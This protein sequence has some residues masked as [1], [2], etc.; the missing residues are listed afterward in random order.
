MSDVGIERIGRTK[1]DLRRFFDVAEKIYENDPHWVAPV[2]AD[3][4]KVLSPKNPFFRHAEIQLF[5]ARRDGAD[6]GRIAAILDRNHNDFQGERTGFFGYFESENDREV[7]DR[8]ID[9][10]ARWGRERG[11]SILRGPAN[12]SLNAEAGLLVD[13]FDA[14]PVFMMTYNPAYY[15]PLLEE[16]GFRKAKDLFAYRIEPSPEPLER[17]ERLAE[18]TRRRT[19][20]LRVRPITRRTLAADLPKVREVYNAAWQGNWG[21]VPMTREEI[22]FMAR[23]LRPL[24]DRD[25][26]CLA[27]IRRRDGSHEP[28]AF[29]V[30]LRDFNQ[31]IAPTRGRLLP[32]G[33]LKFL[34]AAPKVRT[35]RLLTFGVKREWRMRG[36]DA[37]VFAESLR[38]VLRRGFTSVEASWIVEDN[39]PMIR[40]IEFWR[41]HRYK[42]YRLYDR[43]L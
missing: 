38:A 1:G 9:A 40:G 34:L 31:A 5:I 37:V 6:V 21:F 39:F 20:D 32:F 3:L 35:L 43:P 2:R 8:L 25:L 18:R 10:A 33:W 4:A 11:L 23:R 36:I 27:E 19:T 42:T 13:G 29:F 30:A 17:L 16:A 26:S 24:L 22:A 12:P 28:I 7:A 14:P 15:G 41:G